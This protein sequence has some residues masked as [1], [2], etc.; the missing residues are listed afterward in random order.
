M[1]TRPPQDRGRGNVGCA[2]VD[3][4]A[5]SRGNI[6]VEARQDEVAQSYAGCDDEQE[7][8]GMDHSLR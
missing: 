7:T 3:D 6:R 4:E 1:L 8:D 5:D 2:A